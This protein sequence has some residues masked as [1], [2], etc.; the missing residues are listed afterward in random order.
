MNMKLHF[1]ILCRWYTN[2]SERS[3]IIY[4]DFLSFY[5]VIFGLLV[6][7]ESGGWL[8]NQPAGKKLQESTIQD[9]R[10]DILPASVGILTAISNITSSI[11]DIFTA[12]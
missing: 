2:L 9:H 1:Q 10:P 11:F 5:K 3:D 7:G 8:D 4:R 12:F 6:G